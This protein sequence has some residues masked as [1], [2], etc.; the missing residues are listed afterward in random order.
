M[1]PPLIKE[2]IHLLKVI[3]HFIPVKF[4][5]RGLFSLKKRIIRVQHSLLV[6]KRNFFDKL[7]Y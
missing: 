6:D 7:K 1:F 4:K 5:A 2:V 3:T